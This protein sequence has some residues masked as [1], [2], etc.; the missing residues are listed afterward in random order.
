MMT[1]RHVRPRGQLYN[2]EHNISNMRFSNREPRVLGLQLNKQETLN[3]TITNL[4]RASIRVHFFGQL[5]IISSS[6]AF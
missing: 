6:Y 1:P 4:S 3:M 2:A 5:R